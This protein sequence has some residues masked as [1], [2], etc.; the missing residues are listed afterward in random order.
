MDRYLEANIIFSKFSREYMQLK[1]DLPIRPSEMGVLNI[2]VRREGLFTPMKLAEMLEVSKPMVATHIS[3]LEKKGYITRKSLEEDKRS[4]YVIPT[5]K[6]KEL[7]KTATK[8]MNN[9][10]A[11]LEDSLGESDFNDLVRLIGKA[12]QNLKENI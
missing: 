5:N 8:E 11:K 3:V 4:F 12:V 1:S 2:I 9:Q 10:L 6:A 7:V